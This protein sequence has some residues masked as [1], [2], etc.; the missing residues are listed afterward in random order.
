MGSAAGSDAGAL[1]ALNVSLSST[2]PTGLLV[3]AGGGGV[4]LVS[5]AADDAGLPGPIPSALQIVLDSIEA[6]S[7]AAPMAIAHPLTS[8]G[9]ATAPTTPAAPADLAAGAGGG[10]APSVVAWSGNGRSD[11]A[12]I[13]HLFADA[14]NLIDPALF[15][16]DENAW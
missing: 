9:A 7:Q 14:D 1:N 8:E 3:E 16:P 12:Y 5:P 4:T 15:V 10:S 11:K 6:A 13:D 2:E